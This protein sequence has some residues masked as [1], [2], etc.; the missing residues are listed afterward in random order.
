M[1]IKNVQ[2]IA[3][4]SGSIDDLIS[5]QAFAIQDAVYRDTVYKVLVKN[6]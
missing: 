5:S 3:R 1:S 4:L 2:S 6:A